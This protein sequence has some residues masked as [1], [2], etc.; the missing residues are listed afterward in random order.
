MRLTKLQT[1]WSFKTLVSVPGQA[2]FLYF[3]PSETEEKGR[4]SKEMDRRGRGADG[5]PA[6]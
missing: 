6:P 5:K 4:E 2:F 1:H 3:D